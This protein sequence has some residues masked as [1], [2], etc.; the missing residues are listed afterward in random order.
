VKT[1]LARLSAH[2]AFKFN[3]LQDTVKEAAAAVSDAA[4]AFDSVYQ[5]VAKDTTGLFDNMV[6]P[7]KPK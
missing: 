3:L 1:N 5:G 2:A 6:D 7:G 4:T